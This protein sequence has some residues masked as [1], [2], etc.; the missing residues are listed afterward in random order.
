MCDAFSRVSGGNSAQCK[1]ALL[2]CETQGLFQNWKTIMLETEKKDLNEVKKCVM[3]IKCQIYQCMKYR[4]LRASYISSTS[5]GFS[6][7]LR[8]KKQSKKIIV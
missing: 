1:L 4:I 6:Q 3:S 8:S 5:M 7:N 2:M